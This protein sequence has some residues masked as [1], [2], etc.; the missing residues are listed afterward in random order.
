[1]GTLD[2]M[3]SRDKMQASPVNYKLGK[4]TTEHVF[5]KE[6]LWDCI[7]TIDSEYKE[8]TS[9][10]TSAT[11]NLEEFVANRQGKQTVV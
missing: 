2:I 3:I 8:T 11:N 9:N 6:D 7:E 1:M 10:N 5:T 4:T